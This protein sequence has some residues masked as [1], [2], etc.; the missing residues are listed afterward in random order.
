MRTL[1]LICLAVLLTALM[2]PTAV[3]AEGIPAAIAIDG[4]A[5]LLAKAAEMGWHGTGTESD[6]IVIDK[7]TFDTKYEQE[8]VF[9]GNTTLHLKMRDCRFIGQNTGVLLYSTSNASLEGCY[10]TNC[11][12]GVGGYGLRQ[13]EIF[14]GVFEC[15]VSAVSMV[16]CEGL[17][18]RWNTIYVQPTGDEHM[19]G[20]SLQDCADCYVYQSWF[21]NGTNYIGGCRNIT[22]LSCDFRDC[23]SGLE[24]VNSDGVGLRV[25]TMNNGRNGI[26]VG[27]GTSNL[28][29]MG[30][31]F[32]NCAVSFWSLSRET[33]ETLEMTATNVRG[34]PILFIRDVDAEGG[35]ISTDAH[36]A[37]FF[38]VSN[39]RVQDLL[40]MDSNGITLAYCAEVLVKNCT[41]ANAKEYAVRMIQSS[42]CRILD[43]VF[44]GGSSGIEMLGWGSGNSAIGNSISDSRLAIGVDAQQED[45][46]ISG[47]DIH[48]CTIGLLLEGSSTSVSDNAL[49]GCAMGGILAQDGRQVMLVGNAIIGCGYGMRLSR[50]QEAEVESNTIM[51]AQVGVIIDGGNDLLYLTGNLVANCTSHGV[52]YATPGGDVFILHNRFVGNNGAGETYSPDHVQAYDPFGSAV[53]NATWGNYWSDWTSSGGTIGAYI[54]SAD[55]EDAHPYPMLRCGAP[56]GLSGRFSGNDLRVN[57]SAPIYPGFEKVDG[58]AIYRG[59]SPDAMSRIA[60]VSGS[61]TSYLDSGAGAGMH[62]YQVSAINPYGESQR[63]GV[64]EAR[65]G[66]SGGVDTTTIVVVAAAAAGLIIIAL[67]LIRRK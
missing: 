33:Y 3:A 59:D 13:T 28:T 67:L 11:T 32:N 4:D 34:K 39:A 40:Q 36:E 35:V 19:A 43:G 49:S 63:S 30:S 27:E 1:P 6:P 65:Q 51:G 29:M 38:N 10:F 21:H 37:L 23:E 44:Y 22:F 17:D 54:I 55:A 14:S 12:L 42:H 26:V 66:T 61:L 41:G 45:V 7:M 25:S 48:T 31:N 47:N 2:P 16:E 64:L 56:G 60:T 18:L 20:L 58:Y 5:N 52:R 62:Y 46:D 50:L 24:I 53:W 15:A 9:I 8:A 57:W